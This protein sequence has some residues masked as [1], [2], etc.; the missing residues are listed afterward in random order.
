[1]LVTGLQRLHKHMHIF[2]LD[3]RNIVIFM[4]VEHATYIIRRDGIDTFFVA[5]YW[6]CPSNGLRVRASSASSLD[7]G[8]RQASNV[9]AHGERRSDLV[10]QLF[11]DQE[12]HR[13]V[14]LSSCASR[15]SLTA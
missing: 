14:G 7:F 3:K 11:R 10:D 1:M 4:N 13:L 9:D 6:R 15:R 8:R 5:Q 2:F 12:P